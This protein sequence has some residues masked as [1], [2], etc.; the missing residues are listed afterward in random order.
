VNF[1]ESQPLPVEI[2]LTFAS[3]CLPQVGTKSVDGGLHSGV[4]ISFARLPSSSDLL[5]KKRGNQKNAATCD[6]NHKLL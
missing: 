6:V 3:L 4:R 1:T 5:Q 2:T